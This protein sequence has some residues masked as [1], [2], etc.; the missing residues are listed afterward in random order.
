MI[1]RSGVLQY[2]LAGEVDAPIL[3]AIDG[4]LYQLAL[5][6]R[7]RLPTDPAHRAEERIELV[8]ALALFELRLPVTEC[9]VLVHGLI[10]TF[11][12]HTIWGIAANVWMFPNESFL[13]WLGALINDRG[14]PIPNLIHMHRAFLALCDAPPAVLEEMYSVINVSDNNDF[15]A[16]LTGW[17]S[18]SQPSVHPGVVIPPDQRF[19]ASIQVTQMPGM[20]MIHQL[21]VAM[22]WCNPDVAVLGG[23]FALLPDKFVLRGGRRR[24]MSLLE[25]R[26]RGLSY[27]AE[28]SELGYV[29][30]QLYAP[31]QLQRVNANVSIHGVSWDAAWREDKRHESRRRCRSTFAVDGDVLAQYASLSRQLDR[32]ALN[33]FPQDVDVYYGRALMFLRC[34]CHGISE[35]EV[36]AVVSMWKGRRGQF[37]DAGTIDNGSERALCQIISAEC[38]RDQTITLPHSEFRGDPLSVLPLRM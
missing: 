11:D 31:L 16:R 17:L 15:I 22:C 3:K 32:E 4:L 21:S 7:Y 29:R 25:W 19:Y 18:R 9:V 36:V 8:T 14:H 34:R 23:L 38:L 12:D 28:H 27:V 6:T 35:W 24:C 30:T 33:W 2:I 13:G 5:M 20:H 37:I 10:Y 1:T 26:G